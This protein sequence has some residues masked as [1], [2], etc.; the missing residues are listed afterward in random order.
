C[1]LAKASGLTHA[2][3]INCFKLELG[4]TPSQYVSELRTNKA[5]KLLTETNYKIKEIAAMCGYENEYYFSNDFKKRTM[6]NPLKFR[7]M[8]LL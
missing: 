7:H 8:H 5:K 2:Q 3:F 1:D 4:T 6:L